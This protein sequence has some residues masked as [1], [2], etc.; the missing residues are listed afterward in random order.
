MLESWGDQFLE[1]QCESVQHADG[2]PD[3]QVVCLADGLS[4]LPDHGFET[5]SSDRQ[6]TVS[7]EKSKRPSHAILALLL[8]LGGGFIIVIGAVVYFIYQLRSEENVFIEPAKHSA[9][10]DHVHPVPKQISG[11][12]LNGTA[13]SLPKPTYPPAARAVRA[14]GAVSVQ[15]LVNEEGSVVAASAVSGHSL[16]RPAAVKA[17][18]AAKFEP[19]LM[20]GQPIK[21]SGMLTYDF[22]P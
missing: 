22:N 17:A 19:R 15:V 1:T 12:V 21:V 13:T 5:P 16:L 10:P 14:S 18:R 9:E 8:L 6:P 4:L 2:N 7:L 11:G 3:D 20:S